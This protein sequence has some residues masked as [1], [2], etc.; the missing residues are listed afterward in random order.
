MLTEESE[1]VRSL[2]HGLSAITAL[3]RPGGALTM[4]DVA[5]AT[6]MTRPTSRRALLTLCSLGYV[7]NDDGRFSLTPAVLELGY[8]FLSSLNIWD[9]SRYRMQALSKRLG[10]STSV[11]V[12]QGRHAIYVARVPTRRITSIVPTIGTRL[13]AHASSLGK[14]LLAELDEDELDRFLSLRPL[15]AYTERTI[16]DPEQL[17]QELV[18]IRQNGWCMVDQ[19]LEIGL[20]SVAVPLRHGTAEVVASMNVGVHA[21]RTSL[22]ELRSRVLPA[23]IETAQEISIDLGRLQAT[24]ESLSIPTV[25]GE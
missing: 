10:E 21:S 4:S 15:R 5:K 18:R 9:V 23:L 7:S 17:R 8:A 6:G 24:Q 22:D 13:P 14:V 2:R 19:E 3:S 20:R 25:V 11:A 1:G 16:T 12:L